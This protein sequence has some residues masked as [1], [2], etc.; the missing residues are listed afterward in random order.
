M[1]NKY[2]FADLM[3]F[4]SGEV[5]ATM[6]LSF[7]IRYATIEASSGLLEALIACYCQQLAL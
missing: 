4:T 7:A 2:L 6:S 3:L 5:D 1:A